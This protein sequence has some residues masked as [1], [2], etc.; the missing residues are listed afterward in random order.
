MAKKIKFFNKARNWAIVGGI[1][2]VPLGFFSALVFWLIPQP[3]SVFISF[4]ASP[5][6]FVIYGLGVLS[7]MPQ[8]IMYYLL[9][10]LYWALIFYLIGRFVFKKK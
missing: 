2:G 1:I 4:V 9:S 3:F 5:F 6:Y 8:F 10:A 7:G